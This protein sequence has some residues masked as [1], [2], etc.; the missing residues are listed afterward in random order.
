MIPVSANEIGPSSPPGVYRHLW[1]WVRETAEH[2]QASAIHWCD[3]SREEYDRLCGQ[4][5]DAGTF[6]RLSDA[7][8][9]NSYLARSDP[10]DVARVEGPDVHLLQV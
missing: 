10:D 1:E 3:G 8:R 7:R 2:T 9:P 6:T 5:V 4:L